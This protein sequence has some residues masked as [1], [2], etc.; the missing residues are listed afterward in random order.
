ML[1]SHSGCLSR[2]AFR[3]ILVRISQ[4]GGSFA[5][6]ENI[7]TPRVLVTVLSLPLGQLVLPVDVAAQEQP[8]G[9]AAGNGD[10]TDM[11]VHSA[12]A[13]KPAQVIPGWGMVTDE[14]GDCHVL[15]DDGKLTIHVPGTDKEHMLEEHPLCVPA[16]RILAPLSGDFVLQVKVNG[17]CTPESDCGQRYF[18]AWAAAGLVVI[19]DGRNFVSLMRNAHECECSRGEPPRKEVWREWSVNL[20]FNVCVDG[21][22]ESLNMSETIFPG[23]SEAV[24]LRLTRSGNLFKSAFSMDGEHWIPGPVRMQTAPVWQKNS[25]TGGVAAV[26]GTTTDFSPVLSGFFSEAPAMRDNQSPSAK[27]V[28][29]KAA[30]PAGAEKATPGSAPR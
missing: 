14:A 30:A 26:S 8:G 27:I 3:T 25:L 20:R 10:G 28:D 4:I 29:E 16:P 7:M 22:T 18:G 9:K 12:S 5:P 2:H 6:L 1:A 23:E 21:K 19:A 17:S 11:I 24:W 15:F 13:A